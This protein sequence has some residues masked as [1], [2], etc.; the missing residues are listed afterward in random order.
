MESLH[1]FVYHFFIPNQHATSKGLNE[2]YPDCFKTTL[3][4]I[5]DGFPHVFFSWGT[6][7]SLHWYIHLKTVKSFIPYQ[8]TT[9]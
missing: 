2:P 8:Q 3:G 1:R 9:S 4:L 6:I 5:I 7:E